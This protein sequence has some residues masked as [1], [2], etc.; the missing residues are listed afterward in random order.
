MAEGNQI[1]ETG[2]GP[3]A[4]F[5]RTDETLTEELTVKEYYVKKQRSRSGGRTLVRSYPKIGRNEPCPCGSG[6]KSKHCHEG[7]P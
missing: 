4:S 7:K 1:V 2:G 6:K 5:R 3:S